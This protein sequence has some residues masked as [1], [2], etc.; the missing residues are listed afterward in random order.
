L[1]DVIEELLARLDIFLMLDKLKGEKVIWKK[2]DSIIE[3]AVLVVGTILEE[4][5][6][7]EEITILEEGATLVEETIS[8][9]DHRRCIRQFVHHVRKN[10]KC[11]LSLLKEEMFF[12]RTVLRRTTLGIRIV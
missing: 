4:T 1:I 9:E 7:L 2:E 3:I 10:V 8:I 5:I 11:R 12:A 6:T